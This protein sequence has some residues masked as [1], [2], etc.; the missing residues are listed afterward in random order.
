MRWHFYS[1]TV[2]CCIRGGD[3][4]GLRRAHISAGRQATVSSPTSRRASWTRPVDTVRP[5]LAV[6]CRTCPF[7]SGIRSAA[8]ARTSPASV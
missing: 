7:L 5:K 3:T 4:G 1:S 6:G 8:H 2:R